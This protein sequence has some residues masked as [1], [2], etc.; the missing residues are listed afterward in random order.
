[1]RILP[2]PRHSS[3]L[4]YPKTHDFD[5]VLRRWIAVPW[6]RT[7]DGDE[8]SV[9]ES[10]LAIYPNCIGGNVDHAATCIAVLFFQL[11][12]YH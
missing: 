3:L 12:L 11:A 6:T 1:M 2:R 7:A 10:I 4:A 8:N 9:L 5:F